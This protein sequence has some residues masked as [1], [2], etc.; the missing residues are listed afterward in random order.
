VKKKV[1]T[2]E[3]IKKVLSRNSCLVYGAESLSTAAVGQDKIHAKGAGRCIIEHV[4][5]RMYRG[6]VF[7]FLLIPRHV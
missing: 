7:V 2:S 1:R 5:E 6:Y 4:R 3:R